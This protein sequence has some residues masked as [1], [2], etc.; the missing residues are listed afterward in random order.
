MYLDSSD[1]FHYTAQPPPT[2]EK[3]KIG[4]KLSLRNKRNNNNRRVTEKQHPYD[5]W[6]MYREKVEHTDV[7][8]EALI[9]EIAEF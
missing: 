3:K 4:R 5:K 7:K 1:N 6:V 2:N 8:R 9:K